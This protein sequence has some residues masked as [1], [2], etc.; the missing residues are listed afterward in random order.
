MKRFHSIRPIYSVI[1]VSWSL[2]GIN[3]GG[4][5]IIIASTFHNRWSSTLIYLDIYW[6]KQ[7]IL[8]GTTCYLEIDVFK[9]IKQY[10]RKFSYTQILNRSSF[11]NL[12]SFFVLYKYWSQLSVQ[13]KEDLSLSEWSK[14][15]T[16]SHGLYVKCFPSLYLHLKLKTEF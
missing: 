5:C 2:K 14:F 12:G 4:V 1:L 9:P 11:T 13:L 16:L 15:I 10:R 6:Q 3:L 7:E 8:W